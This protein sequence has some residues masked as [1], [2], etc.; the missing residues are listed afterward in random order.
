MGNTGNSDTYPYGI[1][2]TL[3]SDEVYN[4]VTNETIAEFPRYGVEAT[5]KLNELVAEYK[6]AT[7]EE[8]AVITGSATVAA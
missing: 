5:Q 6:A 7:P 1:R 2:A 4:R 8:R 3:D